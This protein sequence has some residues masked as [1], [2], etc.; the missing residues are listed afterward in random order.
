MRWLAVVLLVGCGASQPSGTPPSAPFEPKGLAFGAQVAGPGQEVAAAGTPADGPPAPANGRLPESGALIGVAEVRVGSFI[1]THA[2]CV[3]FV[4][5]RV[6]CWGG[7]NLLHEFGRGRTQPVPDPTLIAGIADATALAGKECAQVKRGGFMCWH[8]DGPAVAAFVGAVEVVATSNHTCVLDA[9]GTVQCSGKN[10]NGELGYEPPANLGATFGMRPVPGATDIAHIVGGAGVCGLRKDGTLYCWGNHPFR[11]PAKTRDE[12]LPAIKP[13]VV[14]GISG[15][16]RMVLGGLP[17]LV[18][19]RD[20]RCGRGWDGTTKIQL[21]SVPLGV[22]AADI[23]DIDAGAY[24]VC[25]VDKTGKVTCWGPGTRPYSMD[26]AV[27]NTQLAAGYRKAR[28]IAGVTDAVQISVSDMYACVTTRSG[29]ARCWGDNEYGE[30]GD[31]TL[32]APATVPTWVSWFHPREMPGP[33]EQIFGCRAAPDV[34]RACQDRADAG[35]RGCQLEPPSDYWAWGGGG[36][37]LCDEACMRR[38]MDELRRR[39]VPA[40]TCT[41]ASDASQGPMNAVPPPEN[42]PA[43]GVAPPTRRPARVPP[44]EKPA[45]AAPP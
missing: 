16:K 23:V 12:L 31:G 6:A 24:T 20:V 5:G 18:F 39:G 43:A 32:G 8:D 22:A 1:E 25:A 41:C 30:L 11:A 35:A 42:K 14:V 36:G 7:P 34:A 38:H 33:G 28:V 44:P 10:Y 2:G 29:H 26:A 4:D 21:E 17:C 37:A 19:D 45:G 9:K 3:R 40:C 27:W 15:V 13:Q